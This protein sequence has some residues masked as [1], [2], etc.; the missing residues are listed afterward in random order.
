M[1][2][3]LFTF[4]V[5]SFL[6]RNVTLRIMTVVKFPHFQPSSVGWI[7]LCG[8]ACLAPPVWST[9]SQQH[10]ESPPGFTWLHLDRGS[11]R[12]WIMLTCF[13]WNTCQIQKRAGLCVQ[14]RDFWLG[15]NVRVCGWFHIWDVQHLLPCGTWDRHHPTPMTPSWISG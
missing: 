15:V 3:E 5:F 2:K 7:G 12:S 9:G 8:S 6:C 4:F 13:L 14:R 1:C 11:Q 10:W